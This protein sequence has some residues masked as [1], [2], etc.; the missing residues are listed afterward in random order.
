MEREALPIT[1]G[2][3]CTVNHTYNS[4]VNIHHVNCLNVN[5]T[6]ASRGI[7]AGLAIEH[8]KCVL[9]SPKSENKAK[10]ITSN[11][12]ALKNDRKIHIVQADLKQFEAP[13]RSYPRQDD[14][15][16]TRST[17]LV[18]N[19]SVLRANPIEETLADYAGIFDVNV[20]A[21]LPLIKAVMPHLRKSG[22]AI[23]MSSVGARIGPSKISLYATSREAI[24][25][26]TKILAQEIG[27]AGYTVNAIAPG[28]VELE[29]LDDVH[30]GIVDDSKWVSG[31]IIS[32]S[33]GFMML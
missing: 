19:A 20:C 2:P 5:F 11:I 3:M 21:L 14:I 16:G 23:N 6:S 30:K 15:S 18:N 22:R 4:S 26:M 17:F 1:A 13:E 25:G 29:M 8:T 31:Q 10:N 9:T 28:P 27:D 32:A 12:E 24:E 7:G 33:G